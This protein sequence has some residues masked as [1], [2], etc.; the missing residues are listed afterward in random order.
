MSELNVEF[1]DEVATN[2]RNDGGNARNEQKE[3]IQEETRDIASI[4]EP[5]EKEK[6]KEINLVPLNTFLEEKKKRKELEKRLRQL[7]EK[8]LDVEILTERQKIK[9]KYVD[10]G[11]QE[12]LADLI[13]EDYSN[14]KGELKRSTLSKKDHLDEDIEDLARD[15]FY[16]DAVSF[17]KEIKAKVKEFKNISVEDAY[18]LVRNPKIKYKELNEDSEQKRILKRRNESSNNTILNASASSPKNPYPLDDNDKKA[19]IKLQELQPTTGWTIEKYFNIMKK[20][21]N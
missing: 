7:E 15:D 1:I 2:E 21:V 17:Q 6:E 14:L 5:T 13:A 4:S 20:G 16:S 18:N 12:D 9:Q 8:E 3:E 19:L 11:Y 10:R